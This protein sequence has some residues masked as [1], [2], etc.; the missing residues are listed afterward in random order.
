MEHEARTPTRE[1]AT[2]PARHLEDGDLLHFLRHVRRR[3]ATAPAD[4]LDA[5][6]SALATLE[7]EA[8]RRGIRLR[9]AKE[10]LAPLVAR[11]K[12]ERAIGQGDTH[13]VD[14]LLPDLDGPGYWRAYRFALALP[15]P[16]DQ[17][18]LLEKIRWHLDVRV[19]GL[20]IAGQR[21]RKVTRALQNVD[22]RGRVQ[23]LRG[24]LDY[25]FRRH[26]GLHE[27]KKR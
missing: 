1:V 25:T 23:R 18:R 26:F 6:V 4:R 7:L 10:P 20:E 27:E 3:I 8:I 24:L 2:L 16:V 12:L 21:R 13:A 11:K 15:E 5:Y 14:E 19:H 17:A 22:A 9:G